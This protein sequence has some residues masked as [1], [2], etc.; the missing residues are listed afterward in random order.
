MKVIAVAVLLLLIAGC[1]TYKQ[2][3]C[4]EMQDGQLS[5][6]Q[7][8]NPQVKQLKDFKTCERIKFDEGSDKQD[9]WCF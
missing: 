8:V 9:L 4:V 7:L 2:Y 1:S 5:C 6:R 3:R